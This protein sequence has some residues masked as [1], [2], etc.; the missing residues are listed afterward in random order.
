M[1]P[2]LVVAFYGLDHVRFTAPTFI[3]DTIHAE[4]EVIAREDRGAEAGLVTFRVETRKS[5]GQTVLVALMK[6]LVAKSQ[7]D[8]PRA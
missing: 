7:V 2:E 8:D 5:D 1:Q 4:T 6:I 3:G